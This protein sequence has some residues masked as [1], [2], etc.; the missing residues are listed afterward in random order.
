MTTLV[1]DLRLAIRQLAGA[2]AFALVAIVTLALGIG[3]N[4]A[5]FSVVDAVLLR[6]LPYPGANRLVSI[7]ERNPE[8]GA[9]I[10]VTVPSYVE[11]EKRVQSFD[12]VG[13]YVFGTFNVTGSSE[14]ER[15]SGAVITPSLLTTIGVQPL[16]G[17]LFTTEEGLPGRDNT[18]ILSYELWRTRFAGDNNVLGKTLTL[19][20][21][22]LTI[23]GVMPTG[24][25]FPAPDMALWGTFPIDL[26]SPGQGPNEHFF[27]VV[28]RLKP[29]V[30][31]AAA[32]A[33]SEALARQIAAT[34]PTAMGNRTFDLTPLRERVVGRARTPLLVVLGAVAFVLL[35]A[36][37][38]M[39]NLLLVRAAARERE[40][41]VRTALGAGR[42]RLIRQLLTES[43]LL[44]MVG[45]SVGLF[46]AQALVKG[47]VSL[48]PANIP[49][50]S[51][52]GLN[53][54]ILVFAIVV[55]V[56]TGIL[57]GLTP[58]MH[59]AKSD[60]ATAF[61]GVGAAGGGGRERAR[62]RRAL[63]VA[64]VAL[65]VILLVGAGLMLR[66][67]SR[68]TGVDPGFNPDHVLTMRFNLP[69]TVY[70]TRPE[71]DATR[72]RV[73]E[74]VAT[75]PGVTAVGGTS[76]L[77]LS[78]GDWTILVTIDGKAASGEPSVA[79]NRL[80]APGYFRAM[81]IPITRGRDI[82]DEDRLGAPAVVLINEAM[83]R[84]YW[85]GQDAIGQ[86][87]KWGPPDSPRAW[88]T[89]V[90]VAAD[91]RHLGLD[92]E[93]VP[94]T[95]MPYSQLPEEVAA[96]ARTMSLT[97]RT[98][99]DPLSMARAVRSAIRAVAAD[100]PLTGIAS[101]DDLRARSVSPRRFTMLLLGS[102]AAL[103]L[104]LSA[105]GIYGVVMYGVTQRTRDIGVRVALGAQSGQV[106]GL[107]LRE[108]M[109]MAVIG[110][111]IGIAGALALT[112]VLRTQL[113]EISPTDPTTFAGIV[114]LLAAVAAIASWLPA[115]RATRVDPMTALRTE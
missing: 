91:V 43:V 23:V 63:I 69:S 49:R 100:V 12:D 21:Q 114:I 54:T 13:A 60:L 111:A 50:L 56:A 9:N 16:L 26:N 71:M 27:R 95:Y 32:R 38:N 96:G 37:A 81:E 68:L 84:R 53:G 57:F 59:A 93:P 65:A 3:A 106:L 112:R 83:A 85:P 99:D 7:Q 55:S 15:L 86:R 20:G 5:I 64:E 34:N 2:P 33:E 97:I 14:P 78:S 92:A 35:I 8:N 66:S 115:R 19:D 41:A 62:V 48:A 10:S 98:V 4:T 70:P 80:I 113:F 108:G 88:L 74:A 44:A 101:M 30:Q 36:C 11:L 45:G 51:E 22:P 39:A 46:V 75:V 6:E 17:R 25:S 42:G 31:L 29:N 67:F 87:L 61:R 18:V 79:E 82:T 72:V 40:I 52:V 89:I 76:H 94:E 58:A 47:I 1:N 102:F 28:A 24:F 90:G 77:P 109:R 104:I 73:R 110:L 107:I 103:A 105:V